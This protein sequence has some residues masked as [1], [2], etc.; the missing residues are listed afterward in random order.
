MIRITK[1]LFSVAFCC[2]ALSF[3]LTGCGEFFAQEWPEEF[4]PENL[5]DVSSLGDISL[6]DDEDGYYTLYVG[7]EYKLDPKV[8][9]VALS[10]LEEDVQK[11][12]LSRFRAGTCYGDSIVKVRQIAITAMSVG[13]DTISFSDSEGDWSTKVPVSVLPVWTKERVVTQRYETIVY[14]QVTVN[15]EAPA[16]NVKFAALCNGELRGRGVSRTSKG[17]T[18][19][20]FRIGSNTASG[21][22]I[23]FEGYDPKKRCLVKFDKTLTFDGGTHGTLSELF[24]LSGKR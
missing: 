24:E 14:A 5:P 15:G 3:L 21:E 6:G 2:L 9:D 20:V 16:S 8:D 18:Y 22:T 17:V 7:D 10:D 4:D 1:K 11:I 13:T 23:T 12:V 19:M